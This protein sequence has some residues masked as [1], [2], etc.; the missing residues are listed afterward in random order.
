MQYKLIAMDLDD[1]LLRNDR[2]ISERTK[3]IIKKCREKGVLVTLATG[4]MYCASLPYAIDLEIDIPLITYQG[5]LLKSTDGRELFHRPI[6]YNLAKDLLS[7]FK[8]RGVHTNIYI[9]D[10][11][12]MFEA[13]SWG[14]NYAQVIN[15]PYQILESPKALYKEP[16]K[17]ILIDNEENLAPLYS[18]L[19]DKYA[20]NIYLTQSKSTFLEISNPRATKGTALKELAQMFNIS[21]E[22]IIAFGDGLND[23]DMIE[24]AGCGVAVGNAR[25]QLREAADII[26]NTNDNDGVAEILEK[27][28][29]K[30]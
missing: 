29:L 16:T 7:F 25:A 20:D 10:K 14:K 13:T 15:T 4:R 9:D 8:I 23:L 11:L 17:I 27:L 22:E 2:T 21:R 28:V 19:M 12:Y 24:Y 3:Q 30:W 6:E 5:A 1:T 18:K 26:A